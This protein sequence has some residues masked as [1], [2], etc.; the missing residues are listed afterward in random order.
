[1]FNDTCVGV[2]RRLAGNRF[3]AQGGNMTRRFYEQG[4]Q[5]GATKSFYTKDHLE[6][7]RDVLGANGTVVSSSL[8]LKFSKQSVFGIG[9]IFLAAK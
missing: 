1:M 5:A 8:Y 2:T 4:G 9:K 7:I 3:T 6:S